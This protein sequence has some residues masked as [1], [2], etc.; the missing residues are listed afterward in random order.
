MR[1]IITLYQKTIYISLSTSMIACLL[2]I[3][4]QVA[5]HGTIGLAEPSPFILGSE[6]IFLC[7]LLGWGLVLVKNEIRKAMAI[8]KRMR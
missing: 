3:A 8:K 6:I 7:M 2:M 1:K 5:F 4:C